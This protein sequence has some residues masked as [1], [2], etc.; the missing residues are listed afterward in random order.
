[1]ENFISRRIKIRREELGLVVILSVLLLINSIAGEISGIISISNFLD[2]SPVNGMLAVWLADMAL[3][4]LMTGIQSL[5]ID[6]FDRL[7][8]MRWMTLAFVIAFIILRL[9]LT[10]N[11]PGAISYALLY[12]LSTQQLMVFPIFF[13]ILSNDVFDMHQT[14]RLFPFIA[15]WGFIGS[16]LGTLFAT[17]Q[18]ALF[19]RANVSDTEVLTFNVLLYLLIYLALQLGF[20]KIKMRETVQQV[21]TVRETL[22]EGWNFVRE[23]ASFRY[24][25][26]AMAAL[27]ICDV[28]IEFRFLAV[29]DAVFTDP[30]AYQRFYSIYRLIYI[31]GAFLVQTFITAAAINK[32]GLKQIFLL[33]P[34]ATLASIGGMAFLPGLIIA[35]GGLLV[36]KLAA[37]AVDEPARKAFQALVPEERRGRVS[38]FMD[39][40]LYAGGS[41]AGILLT[42]LITL[43]GKSLGV[44]NYFYAYLALGAVAAG[45]AIWAVFKMR[46]AYDQSLFNWRLKRRQRRSSI[47]DKLDF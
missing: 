11:A 5:F 45:F 8:I 13:W 7:T 1:M 34:I 40:Y 18:P 41:I 9:M 32:L 2:T 20:R 37:Y 6:R 16:L 33:M 47:L 28:I 17:V 19:A 14:K 30:A 29:S 31:L 4:L 22:T 3:M 43:I 39:S 12:L 35:T 42:G 24:L 23:V 38:I 44:E 46:A 15:G 26:F 21:E 25:M 10:F 36:E 27:A